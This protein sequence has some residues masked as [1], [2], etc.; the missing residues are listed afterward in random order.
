MEKLSAAYKD[1]LTTGPIIPWTFDEWKRTVCETRL[2]CQADEYIVCSANW[3]NDGK[4]YVHNPKNILT[5]FVTCGLRH[6]HC[7]NTFAMIVGFPYSKEAQQLQNTEE[8]GFLTNTNRFVDRVEGLKIALAANQ[9]KDVS[10]VR[11][12]ELHSEDLY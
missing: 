9:I 8:Q 2:D 5:G 6:N 7:I 1:Y 3:Y 4:E 10:A 12:N 11:R